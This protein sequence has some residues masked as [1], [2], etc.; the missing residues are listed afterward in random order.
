MTLRLVS[1]LLLALVAGSVAAWA[2]PRE[3]VAWNAG[4]SFQLG[5]PAD[6]SATQ[7][8]PAG[9]SPVT[10]PHDW[11]I[12]LPIDEKA[13]AGGHGGFFPT[14]TGWYRRE[15]T[16]PESWRGRVIELELEGLGL[17]GEVWI[18]GHSVGR[19][20]YGYLPLRADLTPHLM[21]GAR[22]VVAVRVDNSAQPNSRWYIGSGLLRP[23]WL[24]VTSP[25]RVAADGVWV[26]TEALEGDQARLTL[27]ATLAN[28]TEVEVTP[29]VQH[30]VIAPDGTRTDLPPVEVTLAP[31]SAA[32]RESSFALKW[33]SLW[34]PE[35]PTLYRVVTRVRV[36]GKL[37]DEVTTPFGVRTVRITAERG[38]ELNG[39]TV[40]LNGGNVHH[41]TGPLGGAAFTRAE[42][43]KVQLLKAAGFNAVRTAHNPPSRAFLEACDRLGLLVMNEL[44]DG[45]EKAKNKHDHSVHFREWWTRDVDTWVRRD[46]GHPSVV[47]WSVGNE[48]FERGNA[49]GQ[50]IARDLVARVRALDTTRT[51]TAGVNGLGK[52]DRWEQ[53]DPL[54]AAFDVAGYNY[55]LGRHTDDH[56]RLPQ[57]II[58]AAESYQSEVFANWSITQSHPYVIGDFVW[59]AL[60]YL[61]EAGIGRVFPPGETARKHWEGS[62][63]PWH[64]AYC[65]DLDLTGWRKPVSHYRNIVWDRGERLY[66]AVLTPAPEGKA[67]NTTPWSMPPALASWTWPGQE[68]QTLTV[69]VYSRHEAV[70]VELNRR[71]VGEAPTGRAQEFRARF[72]VP[73][74]P[75]ELVVYGLGGGRIS[76]RLSLRTAQA[77]AQLRVAADRPLLRGDGQDLAFVSIEAVDAQGILQPNAQ[78]PVTV[79]VSG[80]GTLAAFG[81][82]DLA[83][84]EGYAG[85][86]RTL[87]Q[88]RALAVI[89][90]TDAPGKIRVRVQTP[91]LPPQEVTLH[92]Q[93][94]IS[95]P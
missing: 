69:E 52:N 37:Q 50:R 92:S 93:T 63:W 14:G 11:S 15:F 42:E 59:S 47:M 77:A 26:R 9:W 68:G 21:L 57:R 85:T 76:E 27:E 53:L 3:R 34:S 86:T 5:D 19:Q 31:R 79:E 88:G 33:P 72:E 25:V 38:F 2:A 70:R 90:T 55:E 80:A 65:G 40:K 60:D 66:A 35:H 18:N 39:R 4:W 13:P 73:Y 30:T 94:P 62:M 82:G 32:A 49:E 83:S 51:V 41:D 84:R 45:W 17:K 56:A 87:F 61:G 67:W 81:T 43:R 36:A 78:L 16:A 10:L 58:V 23:A 22:N 6:G 44:Y 71:V 75:G 7:V 1:R 29:V 12:A 24:H 64:G 54:F 48:M 28:D 91:G 46:R 8:D 95:S 74:E 89:R 20:V